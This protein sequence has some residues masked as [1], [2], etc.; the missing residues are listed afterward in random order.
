MLIP[1]ENNK[2]YEKSQIWD[3][4]VEDDYSFIPFDHIL[5]LNV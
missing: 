3:L 1:R 5:Y 2:I 4:Q